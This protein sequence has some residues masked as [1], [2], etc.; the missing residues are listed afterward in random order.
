[1]SDGIIVEIV[2]GVFLERAIEFRKQH[3]AAQEVYNK[4]CEEI[5][6]ESYYIIQGSNPS[7]F[8]FLRGNFPKSGWKRPNRYGFSTPFKKNTE[9]WERI[10][11]L[12]NTPAYRMVWGNEIPT[13]IGYKVDGEKYGSSRLLSLFSSFVGW[14]VSNVEDTPR[15]FGR[16]PDVRTSANEILL[17]F[18][19]NKV[20]P[21]KIVWELDRTVVDPFTWEVPEGLVPISEAQ[22]NFAYAQAEVLM[23]KENASDSRIE[24]QEES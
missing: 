22:K 9:M 2:G 18:L 1:M 23:E 6:A 21:E 12:P 13:T 5:G 7:S 10:N 19:G 15:F 16:I 20:D 4:F 11:A 8:R 24:T 14:P 17:D 3:I